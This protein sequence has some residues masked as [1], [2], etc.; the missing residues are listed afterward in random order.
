MPDSHSM[1]RIPSHCHPTALDGDPTRRTRLP[2][3]HNAT[4]SPTRRSLAVHHA[5]D[6]LPRPTAG[7]LIK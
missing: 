4:A 7:E 1:T 2:A 3:I 6:L 5:A